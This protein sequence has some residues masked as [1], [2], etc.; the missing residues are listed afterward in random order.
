MT[1]EEFYTKIKG[2]WDELGSLDPTA[3][4][5]CY[6]CECKLTKKANKSQQ[7]KRLIPFLMKLNNKYHQ[8]RSNILMMKLVPTVA[9]TYGILLQEQVHQVISNGLETK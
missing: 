5:N 1:I 3:V 6:G 7:G 2:D 4:C 8:T 9:K